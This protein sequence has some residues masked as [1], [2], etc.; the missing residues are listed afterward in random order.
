[1]LSGDNGILQKATDAKTQTG[2]GQEKE[3]IAL[4]Y[5]SALAKKVSNGNLSAITD[6]ELND[7]LDSSEATASGNPIIV[8]F[9][10]S[11]NAYEINSN[12]IIKPSTPISHGV[13]GPTELSIKLEMKHTEQAPT[14]GENIGSFTSENVPIPTGFYYVGGTKDTGVVISDASA[15][16]NKGT[17]HEVAQTLVGNQ[18]VWVPVDQNQKLSL[19]VT[20]PEEIT[21]LKLYDP[22]GN[23]IDIGTASGKSY[24]N[25]NI[26]PTTN[27]V[28]EVTV[29]TASGTNSQKLTVRSLY[30]QDR[31]KEQPASIEFAEIRE[32]S[33][34]YTDEYLLSDDGM[35]EVKAFYGGTSI[36]KSTLYQRMGVTTDEQYIETAR[37]RHFPT[38]DSQINSIKNLFNTTTGWRDTEDY[39]TSVNTNGGFYVGRYEAGAT[40]KRTSGNASASV[41]DIVTANGLPVSKVNIDSYTNVTRSQAKGLAEKMYTGKSHLLT[42]AAW[43]RILDWLI[44]TE[45]KTLEKIASNSS[46]WGN[47]SDDTFSGTTGIAKTGV[48]SQTNARSIYDLA[49]NAGE[50]TSAYVPGSNGG[51]DC[52][53][54]YYNFRGSFYPAS[55]RSNYNESAY[56]DRNRF[57]CRT[58]YVAI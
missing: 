6:S 10:K 48:F 1:M 19:E 16:A 15:D 11:G 36:D 28:Y 26:T 58:F 47:Y 50:W 37:Q 25:T 57:P 4:A 24:I 35:N 27:G 14:I 51:C 32:S 40:T 9:T 49:G 20:S 21:E 2:V 55:N 8:T 52:R 3:T 7:E 46:E 43:D 53:G 5:N 54:G 34:K 56:I 13:T 42:N 38:A 29:T 39:S 44:N 23:E 33:A 45:N 18:F 12:G 41:D 22:E 31:F 17:S 30:A